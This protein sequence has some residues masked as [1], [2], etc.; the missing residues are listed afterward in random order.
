MEPAFAHYRNP[1][2][3]Q[4]HA[5]HRAKTSVA[6]LSGWD[7][8]VREIK[9]WPEYREEPLHTLDAAAQRFGIAKLFFKDESQR[10]GR[11]LASFKALGA[12]YAVAVL[13][14]DAVEA[15][16]GQ[17]PTSAQL[18]SDEFRG[19]TGRITVCVATDGNQGRGLAFAARTFGCRCV[20]YIH[21]HVSRTRKEAMER[22]GAIVIRIDGE[23]E[24][25]VSCAKEDA[26]MNGWHFVSST[27]WDD[28]RTDLP[29]QV[30]NG[31]MVMVD[32]ALAQ[33][34]ALGKITHVFMA[35]G[36]GSIPAAVF[37]GFAQR[38]KGSLPRFIIVEPAEADCCYQ[39]AKAGKPTPSAGTLRTIMAGLACREVS[40]AAWTILEWLASDFVTIPDAWSE[41]GMRALA[42]G[43]GDIPIVC[44]ESA[45][46][47]TGLLI[48][49]LTE[50]SLRTA[51]GLDKNSHVLLFGCEGATDPGI[52]T[53]IVGS[54]P[55]AIF[56]RQSEYERLA[57]S[58]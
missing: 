23:Y 1:S 50:K 8:A 9:S 49:S 12:P 56:A 47:S 17:R 33:L 6:N 26:R 27:S 39:S 55:D 29:R 34:P 32:E 36:V 41:E 48:N 51:L 42:T 52:Y 24:A 10:F 20:I 38:L 45:A 22:Y 15:E 44:G 4:P 35:A 18:R 5:E 40:P 3:L 46:G 31:Y 13:L 7:Q 14:A 43:G 21:N 30:M 19:I 58:S 28:Y 11:E 54:T 16:I 25:S 2:R 53:S 37:L 57:R